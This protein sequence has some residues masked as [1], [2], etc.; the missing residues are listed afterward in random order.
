MRTALLAAGSRDNVSLVISRLQI[1]DHHTRARRRV[2]CTSG[3]HRKHRPIELECS[4]CG[5]LRFRYDVTV[6]RIGLRPVAV[7]LA[8]AIAPPSHTAASV[9]A[10]PTSWPGMA[11]G[12]STFTGVPLHTI[13]PPLAATPVH[14][15]SE[16]VATVGVAPFA[17]RAPRTSRGHSIRCAIIAT[18][19][20]CHWPPVCV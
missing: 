6:N 17:A 3:N 8:S 13:E 20:G 10:S 9:T 14:G 7:P 18:P 4:A 5:G 15:T 19:S 16:I 1:V 2:A 12:A 11:G